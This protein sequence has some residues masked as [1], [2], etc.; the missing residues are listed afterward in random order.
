MPKERTVYLALEY[1]GFLSVSCSKTLAALVSLSPDSPTQQL[2]ISLS[3][4]SVFI[5]FESAI[6][7]NWP[8]DD[9]YRSHGLLKLFL[10]V[11]DH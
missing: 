9:N 6:L 7:L 1:T 3:I 8:V 11:G 5:G 10:G 4:L 2:I